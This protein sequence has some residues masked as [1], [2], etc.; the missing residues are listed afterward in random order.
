MPRDLTDRRLALSTMPGVLTEM[1]LRRFAAK[2]PQRKAKPV[3][4]LTRLLR[5]ITKAKP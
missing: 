3:G 1:Q 5:A 2:A 4:F